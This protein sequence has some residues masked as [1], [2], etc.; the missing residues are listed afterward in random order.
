MRYFC[1]DINV[2]VKG[3]LC[4]SLLCTQHQEMRYFCK[5][6]DVN[7]K[8]ILCASLLCTQHQEMGYFCKDINVNVKGMFCVYGTILEGQ[9]EK[10]NMHKLSH[11]LSCHAV[12]TFLFV[13]LLNVG[14]IEQNEYQN[15]KQLMNSPHLA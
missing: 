8:G 15:S 7:V 3:M 2:N 12:F 5:D 6:I 13:P 1:K 4:A 11:P 14:P 10:I 9:R